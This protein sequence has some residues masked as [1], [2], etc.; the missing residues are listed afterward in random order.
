MW[1]RYMHC[2]I[3]CLRKPKSKRSKG[4]GTKLEDCVG[5]SIST[6]S[7]PFKPA[8]ASSLQNHPSQ[9]GRPMSTVWEDMTLLGRKR[10]LYWDHLP[11]G[12]AY[13]RNT[14]AGL[15][16]EKK[17]KEEGGA[18]SLLDCTLTIWKFI[19][20]FSYQATPKHTSR[21][22][23]EHRARSELDGSISL[24]WFYRTKFNL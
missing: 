7:C 8:P 20:R 22:K 11:H 15:R 4:R 14:L 23:H 17:K 3:W 10:P 21:M 12:T 5:A 18:G 9:A 13:S 19:R 2:S 6:Y 24:Q 1:T 16:L